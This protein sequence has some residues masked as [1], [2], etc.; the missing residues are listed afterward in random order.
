PNEKPVAFYH[1]LKLFSTEPDVV[2]GTKALVN[3]HYDEL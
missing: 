1:H 3:E 2:A